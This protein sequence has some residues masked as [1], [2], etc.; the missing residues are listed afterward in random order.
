ML[1]D[2]LAMDF[3]GAPFAEEPSVPGLA[4]AVGDHVYSYLTESRCHVCTSPFRAEVEDFVVQFYVARLFWTGPGAPRG[5][6]FAAA[7]AAF[8]EAGLDRGAIQR[9]FVRRHHP[10]L[11]VVWSV[12][13]RLR[14]EELGRMIAS[15]R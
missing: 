12:A 6:G 4:I 15:S 9:H 7:S 10:L 2:D 5:K 1:E 11:T 3:A 13:Q 14:A 8:V